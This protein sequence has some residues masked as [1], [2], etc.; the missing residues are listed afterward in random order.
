MHPH[1]YVNGRFLTQHRTGVERYAYE[2]CNALRTLNVPF[3][4]VCPCRPILSDYDIE[5]FHIE[6]YGIG[7]SH[8][9]EQC[10]LP[11]YF[12]GKKD[13]VVLG[14]TGL[15]SILVPHKVMTIHDLSFL[16]NPSWFSRA[17]YWYY[18]LMT[19]LAA[20][21]SSAIITVSEFSKSEILRYYSFIPKDKI[22]VVYNACDASKFVASGESS[23]E[24][25]V[26]AV[27]SIDPR[28]N[29]KVLIDAFSQNDMGCK[30]YIVGNRHR[31]FAD[32][33]SSMTNS[34]NIVFLGR[35]GDEQLSNL[36]AHALC[37]V[38]SSLYEGFGLPLLEAMTSGCPVVCSDIPVYHEVCKDS[39]VYFNPLSPAELSDAV[40]SMISMTDTEREQMRQRMNVNLE[41]FSWQ[42]SAKKLLGMINYAFTP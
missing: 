28:K 34:D 26:L 21:T 9:W 42:N 10:V 4:V 3:T 27:S 2:I 6:H 23:S 29:L 7:A 18:K 19:P 16:Y 22:C 13:Y 32:E 38:S 24:P 12:L 15:G 20:R 30:L 33:E 36:Y 14:F 41:R 17:Y 35:V 39:A 31:V 37:F 8:F 40:R 5:G 11:F 1:I 25:Y